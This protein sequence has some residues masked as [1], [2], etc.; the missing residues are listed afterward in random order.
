LQPLHVAGLV[1]WK[2]LPNRFIQ[3]DLSGNDFGRSAGV[4]RKHDDPQPRVF[5][6]AMASG[7]AVLYGIG[8]TE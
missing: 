5:N 2:H 1:G 3:P 6:A 7:R 4:A 8:D